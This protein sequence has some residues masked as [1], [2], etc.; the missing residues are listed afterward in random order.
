MRRLS[1]HTP[2]MPMAAVAA[3]TMVGSG[4]TWAG[5]TESASAATSD[6]CWATAVTA[7]ACGGMSALVA[8]AKAECHLT[9][10][11]DPYTWASYGI[12]IPDFEKKYDIKVQDTNPNGSSADEINEINLYKSNLSVEPDIVEVDLADIKCMEP[13]DHR[14]HLTK[15]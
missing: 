12:L 1:R 9:V 13:L 8:A 11:T 7:S 2:R 3:L 4:V 6:A 5:T 15:P 10:T 14:P